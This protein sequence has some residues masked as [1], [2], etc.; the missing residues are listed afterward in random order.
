MSESKRPV[1]V[2]E[3]IDRKMVPSWNP[4]DFEAVMSYVEGLESRLAEVEGRKVVW[5]AQ[6]VCC[7]SNPDHECGH[8]NCI[9]AENGKTCGE[10]YDLPAPL[11]VG[12][13]YNITITEVEG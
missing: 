9:D 2:Q 8:A 4:D 3:V 5:C 1:E 6:V 7:T 10:L 12:S 13:V 11:E